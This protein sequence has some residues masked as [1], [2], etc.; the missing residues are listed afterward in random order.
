MTACLSFHQDCVLDIF[1][2]V[3]PEIKILIF[4]IFFFHLSFVSFDLFAAVIDPPM[5]LL[6]FQT[7]LREHHQDG[8]FLPWSSY[9]VSV[10]AGNFAASFSL[11][12]LSTFVHF[13]GSTEPIILI[14]VSLERYL[15]FLLQNLSIDEANLVKG[16]GVRSGT[17]ANAHYRQEQAAWESMT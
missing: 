8:Q 15:N 11:K 14:W 3:C 2:W 9:S 6:P 10:V 17:K 4:K 12:F 5:G 7:F 13:S 16:D 1:A